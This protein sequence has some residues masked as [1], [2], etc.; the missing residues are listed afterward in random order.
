MI[1]TTTSATS[2]L[3]RRGDR[4]D[5]VQELQ[6]L[7]QQAGYDPGAIDG[8][9]GPKTE[10]AVKAFQQAHSLEAD[11]I[12]GPLTRAALTSSPAPQPNTAPTPNPGQPRGMSLHIGLNNVNP[13]AYPFP[14][15]V[16]RGCLND[17]NDM[18][19][20][21]QGNGFTNP[22]PQML[23]EAAATSQAVTAAIGAAA[24]TL[25]SGDI[26]FITYSGHGSQVVDV[27]G[28]ETDRLDETWVLWDRQ[29]LDDELR[30]LWAQFR[31]GVR[32]FLL[33]DSCHSGTVARALAVTL[34]P[35]TASQLALDL[36]EYTRENLAALIPGGAEDSDAPQNIAQQVVSKLTSSARDVPRL[37]PEELANYAVSL[38]RREYVAIKQRAS[39][40]AEPQCSVLLI[41]GCQDDQTSADGQR[42]G[43]FTQRLKEVFAEGNV[44][45]YVD[46]HSRIVRRMPARQRP[47]YFWATTPNPAFEAQPPLTI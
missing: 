40:A 4:G 12:V 3:L 32:I 18:A 25:Q 1:M 36:E 31:A 6:R 28:D 30:A 5:D 35:G 23:V 2:R 33:S 15:P 21:A 14:V 16:L 20:L 8:I 41:S 37:I 47:N 9:F 39:R 7:L 34:T 11:G 13:S 45:N 19:S 29:L 43:L 46:L 17:A 27:T 22:A 38:H 26:L 24:A 44:Q 42:N 10:A